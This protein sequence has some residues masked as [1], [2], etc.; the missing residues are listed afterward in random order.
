MKG[1]DQVFATPDVTDDDLKFVVFLR[2][3]MYHRGIE[4]YYIAVL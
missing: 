3:N 2:C 4:L 1:M